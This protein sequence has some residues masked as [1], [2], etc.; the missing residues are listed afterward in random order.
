MIVMWG[1]HGAVS[2][3]LAQVL[4]TEKQQ[5]TLIK[6][7]LKVVDKHPPGCVREGR[8]DELLSD[9]VKLSVPMS[10]FPSCQRTESEGKS[11]LSQ[12]SRKSYVM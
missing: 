2:V 8:T 5:R 1:S 4:K 9:E 10:H 12:S 6:V 11:Y 3:C 7:V